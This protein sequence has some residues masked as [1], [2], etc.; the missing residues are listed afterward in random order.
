MAGCAIVPQTSF[1]AAAA[2][3]NFEGGGG[4]ATALCDPPLPPARPASGNAPFSA[5]P[6]PTFLQLSRP[7]RACSL[8]AGPGD[9]SLSIPEPVGSLRP[10]R[11]LAK[12]SCFLPARHPRAVKAAASWGPPAPL[13]AFFL[14][15]S[16]GPRIVGGGSQF[17]GP[18]PSRFS[19]LVSCNLAISGY[20][21]PN[22][23]F[24]F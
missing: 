19:F 23:N 10:T 6:G 3:L 12:D 21:P 7:V 17:Q 14:S 20:P 24:S 11:S 1:W 16:Q 2:D 4:R 8:S 13:S 5:A 15:F 9:P 18:R 22:H